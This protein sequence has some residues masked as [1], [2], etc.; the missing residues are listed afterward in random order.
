MT[1][2]SEKAPKDCD[3]REWFAS[4][5]DDDLFKIEKVRVHISEND[6]PGRP[7]Q[8]ATCAQCGETITDGREV[9]GAND[10]VLCRNCAFGSYYDVLD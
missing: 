1:N 5:S 3:L 8:V 9:V 10:E 7:R 2:I 4:K 6:L